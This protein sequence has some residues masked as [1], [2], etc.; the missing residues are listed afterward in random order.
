MKE[1]T[2]DRK[3]AIV[4]GA[5]SGI[6]KAISHRLIAMG[7]EV[8]GIGRSFHRPYEASKEYEAVKGDKAWEEEQKPFLT[9][10]DYFHPIQCDLLDTERLLSILEPIRKSG[11]IH[12]L[13]NNAGVAYYGL[14]EE[15]NVKKIQ[16]MMRVN[17]EIPL[18][19]TQYLLR[20]LKKNQGDIVNISSVTATHPSPHGAAY[21]ASKAGLLSFGRSLFEEARKYGLRVCTILPDMTESEL[22]RNA[23]FTV[24]K[25]EDVK[26]KPE[27]V[28][29]AV[30][31]ALSRRSGMNVSELMIR[32]QRN[33]IEKKA[34][35]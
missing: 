32:P 2:E 34:K 15:L 9:E 35:I 21:G 12:L 10:N 26:L 11:R 33:R 22:Y 13:V 19:L 3:I 20:E 5:S 16:E 4:T 6:G 28:A 31:F 30:E 17:L 7:Y 14:H 1:Q 29:D 23:S 24:G 27:E 25:E 18:V 8:Y